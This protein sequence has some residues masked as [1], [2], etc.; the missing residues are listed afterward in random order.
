MG[1][2]DQS[3]ARRT[4][5]AVTKPVSV[6]DGRWP[7]EGLGAAGGDWE[8]GPAADGQEWLLQDV[9]GALAGWTGQA[10]DEVAEYEEDD[11]DE[12]DGG[13]P[14]DFASAAVRLSR[15]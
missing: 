13:H 3:P 1:A 9:E 4:A 6:V 11:D 10:T 8:P 7:D 5:G 14:A 12:S 15:A 2:K